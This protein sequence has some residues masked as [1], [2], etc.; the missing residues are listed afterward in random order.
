MR[1]GKQKIILA[2]K[3]L[4]VVFISAIVGFYFFRDELLQQTL[5]KV[6]NKMEQDYNS[7]FSVKKASFD[8]FAGVNLTD[9]ILKATEKKASSLSKMM[10]RSL[11]TWPLIHAGLKAI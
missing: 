7:T 1:T 6:S 10:E 3:I 8:G 5:V 2:A 11:Q 4:S 9:V